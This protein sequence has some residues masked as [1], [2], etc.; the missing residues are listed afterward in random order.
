MRKRQQMSKGGKERIKHEE[1]EKRKRKQGRQVELE[2]KCR[3]TMAWEKNE[4]VI[5]RRNEEEQF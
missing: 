2:E 3:V 1:E 4:K 5:T